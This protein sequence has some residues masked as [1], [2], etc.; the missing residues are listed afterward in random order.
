MTACRSSTVHAR[1]CGAA[2]V[3]PD[4]VP[5]D[6]G[7]HD[8]AVEVEDDRGRPRVEP[9]DSGGGQLA[10]SAGASRRASGPSSRA[11]RRR[12]TA[13]GA[14]S[15]AAADGSWA[16]SR[17]DRR[18]SS[19]DPRRTTAL[20]LEVEQPVAA[21]RSRPRARR[22]ARGSSGR[23]CR[24]ARPLPGHVDPDGP[25][26]RPAVGRREDRVADRRVLAPGDPA[27]RVA[28]RRRAGQ[29]R[30]D[31]RGD[32]LGR[33]RVLAAAPRSRH[34]LSRIGSPPLR[35]VGEAPLHGS[36]RG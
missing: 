32:D 9:S 21:L 1:P 6:L 35:I 17:D 2:N 15:I 7:V 12:G 31:D 5:P 14:P 24:R 23:A 22:S 13:A 3:G 34:S 8:D 20:E 28:V 25:R 26:A 10:G 16:N 19:S 29:R 11:G 4:L 18:P 36:A 33:H 30:L 27:V